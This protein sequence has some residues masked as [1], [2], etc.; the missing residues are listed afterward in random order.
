LPLDLTALDDSWSLLGEDIINSNRE[1]LRNI[2]EIPF[3][4]SY[5]A[6]IEKYNL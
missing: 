2:E 3:G 4:F 6:Y 5:I 1:F